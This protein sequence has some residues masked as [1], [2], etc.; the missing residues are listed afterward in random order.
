MINKTA[1]LFL[2]FI[3]STCFG[4]KIKDLQVLNRFS[5]SED[6]LFT[7]GYLAPIGQ[8]IHTDNGK[9]YAWFAGGRLHQTQGNYKDRLLNGIYTESYTNKQL[10]RKGTYKKGL[11]KG[12]WYSW[13]ENGVLKVSD[14]YKKGKLNR[15][16]ISYDSLGMPAKRVHFRKGIRNGLEQD[17]QQGK[18]KTIGKYK[19]GK[20]VPLK[21][22]LPKRTIN[23]IF[24]K[25]H[26]KD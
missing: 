25:H 16:Q 17:Y 11:Q 20:S 19:S 5:V 12:A 23:A 6:G 18:W 21:E 13:R 24:K 15:Y 7:E 22:P 9:T 26:K 8:Y 4:Q 1:T 14:H 2:L 10:A 3:A